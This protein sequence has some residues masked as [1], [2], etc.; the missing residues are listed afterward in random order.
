[1]QSVNSDN[2]NQSKQDKQPGGFSLVNL[3]GILWSMHVLIAALLFPRFLLPGHNAQD[4]KNIQ[5]ERLY[6][7]FRIFFGTLILFFNLASLIIL[8]TRSTLMD[9][10]KVLFVLGTWILV[11]FIYIL[12]NHLRDIY[13]L[14]A[15]LED[16]AIQS[17]DQSVMLI[18][19][20]QTALKAGNLKLYGIKDPE[21][22]SFVYLLKKIGPLAALVM[23]KSNMKDIA[24]EALKL[25]FSGTRLFKYLF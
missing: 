22:F 3:I 11:G 24:L 1:M 4:P 16:D 21:Q 19:A 23:Q 12:F 10:A 18:R 8:C 25:A 15:V 7:G 13:F 5:K 6:T 17:R 2:N 14:L 20:G 9:A